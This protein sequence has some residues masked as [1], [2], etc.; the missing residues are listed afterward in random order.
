MK[1]MLISFL[2]ICWASYTHCYLYPI[3]VRLPLNGTQPSSGSALWP[4][5]LKH[6]ITESYLLLNRDKFQFVLVS[7][8]ISKCE[9]EIIDEIT[10]RY[11]N[12]IFPPKIPYGYPSVE[13]NELNELKI[14]IDFPEQDQTNCAKS[15]YPLIEDTD[16]EK[17]I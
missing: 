1:M 15:Y 14:E 16:D 8:K 12:I 2:F 9:K 3:A 7:S 10:P 5:P 17:C 13:H 4:K 11:R 6:T